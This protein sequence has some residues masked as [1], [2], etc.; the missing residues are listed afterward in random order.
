LWK[1]SED[2]V[3]SVAKVGNWVSLGSVGSTHKQDPNLQGTN[4]K[5]EI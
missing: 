1:K 4:E 3:G 5:A 2:R